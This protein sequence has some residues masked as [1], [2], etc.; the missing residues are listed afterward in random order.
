MENAPKGDGDHLKGDKNAG[1]MENVEE[2]QNLYVRS[3]T[4]PEAFWAEQAR[5]YL[6]WAREW[7][8]VLK[9]DFEIPTIEWFG[10][11]RLNASYNCL[12]RHLDTFGD[13]VAYYWEGDDPFQSQDVT[14]LDL[15][16]RVNRLAAFLKARGVTK[17][18]RV[19]IYL[20]M[21]VELPVAML[22]CARIGAIHAV[23]GSTLGP[24]AVALRIRDCAA[25]V[26]VTADRAYCAGHTTCLKE[27]LDE[28][29]Q[30]CPEVE[31]LLVVDRS[32]AYKVHDPEKEFRWQDAVNDP[33]LLGYVEPEPMDSEDPLCILHTSGNSGKPLAVVHT[34]GGYLLYAAMTTRWVFGLH[35]DETFWSTGD[36]GSITGHTY[37]VYGP[38]LNGSTTILF[39]GMPTYPSPDRLWQI[40]AKHRVDK[41]CTS[42]SVI[43]LLAGEGDEHVTKHDISSLKMLGSTGQPLDDATRRW[44]YQR[45]GQERCPVLDTWW[46]TETGGH[47]IGP[48]PAWAST[49][50]AS[51]AVPFFGVEPV[52]LD[53]D[54]GE[55]AKFPNQEGALFIR[56]PWPGM[57][58]T[59]FRDPERFKEVYFARFPS[60]FFTGDGAKVDA[61]GCYRIT[62]RIDEVINPA[63]HRVAPAEVESALVAHPDV[64]E[65]AVVG[66]PHPLKGEGLYAF[67]I[68]AE[69]AVKSE[70]LLV[71]LRR[72]ITRR[73]GP[74]AVPDAIQWAVALPK[75]RSGKVLRQLLQRIASGTLR[76]T[77]DVTVISDPSIVESLIRDRLNMQM[78]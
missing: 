3:L 55:E 16:R 77:G 54:T 72:L 29:L 70:E 36:L 74:M 44:Y 56:R 14:Y 31:T 78:P 32:G 8:F 63:G 27:N 42:P 48:L 45:V 39:E 15:F 65:A 49:D 71:Q 41:F 53:L 60:L 20:P 46:Q 33:S 9:Y 17:G 18:E 47:M 75:T 69:G 2:Y 24:E 43:R 50:H 38:L 21:I 61:Q 73:I 25:K 37:S 40:I 26:V 64:G 23:V 7:D 5:K 76:S 51:C 4:E 19:L 13:K 1:C 35:E 6:S 59:L 57:A 66:F 22:A 52:I 10:G 30:T 34:H 28:V 58:R 67:V 62:G 68:P 12:D 11:A